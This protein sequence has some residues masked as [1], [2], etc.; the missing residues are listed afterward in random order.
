VADRL[1]VVT[2]CPQEPGVVRL[3]LTRGG[4]PERVDAAGIITAL[5]AL[6]AARGLEGRVSVREG[7]AG[8]C[9]RRGRT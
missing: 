6:V 5:R 7:C 3:P 8:G 1:L 4:R 9:G 2:V